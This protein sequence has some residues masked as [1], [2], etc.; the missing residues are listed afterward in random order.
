[1]I[2]SIS[3]NRHDALHDD[4]RDAARGPQRH[5]PGRNDVRSEDVPDASAKKDIDER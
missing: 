2:L 1:M 4:P 3:T 5:K